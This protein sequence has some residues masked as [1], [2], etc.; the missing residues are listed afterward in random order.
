MELLYKPNRT[1]EEISHVHDELEL[2]VGA[3]ATPSRR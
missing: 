1:T 2:L 3:G